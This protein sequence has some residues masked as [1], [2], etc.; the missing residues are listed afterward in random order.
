MSAPCP[1]AS[2][3]RASCKR[4]DCPACGPRWARDVLKVTSHNLL[5]YG[6]PVV[7]VSVTAPGDERLP[8]DETHCHHPRGGAHSGKRGCRVEQRPA[9]EWAET[10][11]W[12][13]AALRRAAAAYARRNALGPVVLLERVWEPQKRGVPHVH[14]VLGAGTEAELDA[15]A[16]FVERLKELASEYDFGFVDARGKKRKDD[17]RARGRRVV[18]RGVEL[19]LIAGEQAARYLASYLA[20]RS[21]YKA[22]IRETVADPAMAALMG[23]VRRQALPLWWLTPKLTRETLVTMRTLRRARHLWAT[24]KGV[25][26]EP[27]HWRDATDALVAALVFRRVFRRGRAD[28]EPDPDPGEVLR[29]GAAID[30][31]VRRCG[32][33]AE[34]GFRM[35]PWLSTRYRDDL[36]QLVRSVASPVV[37]GHYAARPAADALAV[38]A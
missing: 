2:I 35:A 11:V 34:D 23:G 22:T 13:F 25:S 5:A 26:E 38:A 24:F 6:R 28:D 15:A 31:R 17:P 18:V 37:E 32:G 21:R 10:A 14:L 16:L 9:R 27:P 19:K 30:E 33:V 36:A 8:W 20:G 1:R 12:R 4:R 7:L 3:W 29:L